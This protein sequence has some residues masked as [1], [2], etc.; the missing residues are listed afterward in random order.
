VDRDVNRDAAA[1][2]R[3]LDVPAVLDGTLRRT[4]G[5][6]RLTVRLLDAGSGAVTWSATRDTT[7]DG[8]FAWRDEVVGA[9]ADRVGL[10]IDDAA[11]LRLQRRVTTVAAHDLYMLGRFRW[12]EGDRGDLLE[13]SAYFQLAI[14]ADSTFAPAW[15]ALADA[16]V[17]LPRLTRFPPE[18]ARVDGAAAARTALRLDPDDV[19]AHLALAQVMYVYENDAE[20]ARA[21]LERAADLDP[22]NAA[23][24]ELRCEL[25]LS[26]GNFDGAASHC[27]AARQRDPLAFRAA[28]LEGDLLRARGD[29]RGA[30]V[31]LDSLARSFPD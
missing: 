13:A 22:G 9:V 11:R 16:Y 24:A 19:E 12:A 20:G 14:E 27:T 29:L 3:G 17:T 4:G 1:A 25:D 26:R 28:W 21:H 5:R 10:E 30:T 31:R 8:F 18:R 7:L 2:A 6:L 15:S 23:P